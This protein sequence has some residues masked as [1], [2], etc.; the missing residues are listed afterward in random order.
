MKH[1][2]A[3]RAATA[4]PVS[5]SAA[6]YVL[7]CSH[8]ELAPSPCCLLKR[9]PW[10]AQLLSN[11]LVYR[12]LCFAAMLVPAGYVAVLVVKALLWVLEDKY[13]LTSNVVFHIIAVRVRW[14]YSTTSCITGYVG[15]Y[16]VACHVTSQLVNAS[17][18]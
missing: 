4:S 9:E 3:R 7:Q 1:C 6:E 5:A 12:W 14:C 17:D 15:Y 13:F 16:L 11:I 2:A 10:G 8:H 18:V